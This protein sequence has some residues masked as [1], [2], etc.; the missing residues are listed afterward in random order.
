MFRKIASSSIAKI[1]T[2]SKLNAALARIGSLPMPDAD[3]REFTDHETDALLSAAG[4]RSIARS[5]SVWEPAELTSP[6]VQREGWIFG[7]R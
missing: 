5:S 3:A 4:L 7:M 1:R 6:R 2:P